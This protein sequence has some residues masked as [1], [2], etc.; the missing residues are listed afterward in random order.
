M[1]KGS[2][3]SGTVLDPIETE[4]YPQSASDARTKWNRERWK[5]A[6]GDIV[7]MKDEQAHRNNWS[8]GSVVDAAKSE[9]GRVRTVTVL[10]FSDGQ[11]KT[12]ERPISALVLLVPLDG[13]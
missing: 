1:E 8:L 2:V 12:Y 7:M 11:K 13:R 5:L 10:T 9:D 4:I 6:V 3:P